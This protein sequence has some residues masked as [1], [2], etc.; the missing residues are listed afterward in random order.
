MKRF[1]KYKLLLLV[2]VLV[3]G[4]MGCQSDSNM[5][6]GANDSMQI[7]LWADMGRGSGLVVSPTSRGDANST[8]GIVDPA[9]DTVLTIGMARID[10]VYSPT[11]PA[12]LD[13]GE[14][15]V[16]EMGRPNPDNSYIRNIDFKSAAQF[17]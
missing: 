5:G 1:F 3:V 8:S 2:E 7:R 11:Y 4:A 14:P 9:T 12:F 17:F 16:A 6:V 10:E 15:I 13:C